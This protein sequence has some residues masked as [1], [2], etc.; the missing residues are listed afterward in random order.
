M[1]L[2][3]SDDGATSAAADAGAGYSVGWVK[4]ERSD[5]VPTAESNKWWARPLRGLSPPYGAYYFMLSQQIKTSSPACAGAGS[6]EGARI[7]ARPSRRMEASSVLAAILRDARATTSRELL[8]M[9]VV[10][11]AA[12][13]SGGLRACGANPP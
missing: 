7:C 11:V 3:A 6:E 12:S 2:L 8:R 13:L 4:P 1:E 9:T 10:F 5:G